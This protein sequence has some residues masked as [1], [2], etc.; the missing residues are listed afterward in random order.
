MGVTRN[1]IGTR[2]TIFRQTKIRTSEI[3]RRFRLNLGDL[4]IIDESRRRKRKILGIYRGTTYDVINFKFWGRGIYPLP[5]PLLTPMT[6]EDREM[7]TVPGELAISSN[8][9]EMSRLE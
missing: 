4:I 2:G 8:E 6:P 5:R 1:K 9:K 7:A 3:F